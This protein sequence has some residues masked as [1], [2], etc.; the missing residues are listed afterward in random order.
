MDGSPLIIVGGN[1]PWPG[2]AVEALLRGQ[3]YRLRRVDESEIVNAIHREHPDLILL[4]PQDRRASLALCEELSERRWAAA[5]PVFYLCTQGRAEETLALESGVWD[6]V[7]CPPDPQLLL[8][9]IR[10]AI[11]IRRKADETINDGLL[12]QLTGC[13]NRIGLHI[14]LKQEILIARRR[15]TPLAC[16]VIA[17]DPLPEVI[18]AV[19]EPEASESAF[20]MATDVIKNAVRRS[21]IL[22]HHT[23]LEFSLVAQGADRNG[24]RKLVGRLSKA[25]EHCPVRA[26]ANG[27]TR[28][29]KAIVG[30]SLRTSWSGSEDPPDTLIDEASQALELAKAWGSR[31]RFYAHPSTATSVEEFSGQT[32]AVG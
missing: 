10:N 32:P 28:P 9:R 26:R 29:F 8:A 11:R 5:I 7:Q 6:A 13:Y 17:L 25:F 3:G 24:C 30:I 31:L 12:D 22:A 23:D 27:L 4:S 21:D 16:M 20:R 18:Q 14:L 15:Q 2:G 1:G 19:G